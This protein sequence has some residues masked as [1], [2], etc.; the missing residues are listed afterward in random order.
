MV[1]QPS[2]MKIS[3]SA[4]YLLLLHEMPQESRFYSCCIDV[5]EMMLK[6]GFSFAVVLL[7]F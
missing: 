5:P 3:C 1:W 6:Y 4:S 2:V 7:L